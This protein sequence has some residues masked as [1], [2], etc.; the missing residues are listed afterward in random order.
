[1]KLTRISG[2]SR[3]TLLDDYA[4][5]DC[6]GEGK[7]L[8]FAAMRQFLR[9]LETVDGPSLYVFTSIFTLCFVDGDSHRLPIIATGDPFYRTTEAGD[10]IASFHIAFPH[11]PDL[12]R[13]GENWTHWTTQDVDEAIEMLLSAIRDSA[14][15]P[16][17]K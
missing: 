16:D 4:P 7:Q 8:A 2:Q 3:H 14:F 15:A 11:A 9:Q 1:M 13:S 12:G 17:V 5:E 6:Y 10:W